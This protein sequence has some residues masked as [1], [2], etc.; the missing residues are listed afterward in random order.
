MTFDVLN[1]IHENPSIIRVSHLMYKTNINCVFIRDNIL[2]VLLKNGL[3]E[4]TTLLRRNY[5]KNLVPLKTAHPRISW[6]TTEKGRR[7]LEAYKD[8]RSLTIADVN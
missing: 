2:S 4:E 8:L 1:V 5:N 3:I 7:L 6:K